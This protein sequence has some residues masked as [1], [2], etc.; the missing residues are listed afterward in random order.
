MQVGVEGVG[1]AKESVDP[2]GPSPAL[3]PRDRRL[4]GAYELGEIGLGEAPLFPAVGDL[5]GDLGEEPALLGPGEPRTNSLHGLTHISIMLYIAV[6]RY[7]RSIAI[8]TAA[9]Y[10]GLL[11]VFIAYYW[12]AVDLDEDVSNWALVALLGV[13]LLAGLAIGRSHA[14]L[15]LPLLPLLSIPVPVPEDAYEP[16]P[17]WFVMLAYIGPVAAVV[18]LAG[19]GARKLGEKKCPAL[20]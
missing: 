9:L 10:V 2:R 1:D 6:V 15:L 14:L 7:R 18:M 17:L 5:P 13:Q 16:F 11:M 12:R 20:R 8:G 19:I 3:E 4:G